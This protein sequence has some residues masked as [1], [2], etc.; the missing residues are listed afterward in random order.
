MNNIIEEATP[1]ILFQNSLNLCLTHFRMDNFDEEVCITEVNDLVDTSYP[2]TILLKIKKYEPPSS[3]PITSSLESPTAL[4]LKPLFD[5]PTNILPMVPNQ[6]VQLVDV[7][8]VLKE[9]VGWDITDTRDNDFKILM[10]DFF[11]FGTTFEDC[12]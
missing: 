4:E 7:L 11:V 1:L 2:K 5:A 12:H 6:K 10:T 9:A 3:P 8:K